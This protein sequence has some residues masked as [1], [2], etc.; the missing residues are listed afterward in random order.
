MFSLNCVHCSTFVGSF[1]MRLCAECG[2]VLNL[3][4]L[5]LAFVTFHGLRFF[6]CHFA[7]D[8][9]QNTILVLDFNLFVLFAEMVVS[10]QA[11]LD[12]TKPHVILICGTL[13]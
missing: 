4:V 10:S 2:S 1:C 13:D 5:K 3:Y 7:R 6:V 12:I 11:S 8:L 9:V